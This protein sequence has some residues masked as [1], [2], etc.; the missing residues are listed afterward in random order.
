MPIFFLFVA[1]IL[2]SG[3]SE[4]ETFEAVADREVKEGLRALRLPGTDDPP[5][6]RLPGAK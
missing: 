3:K 4:P 6:P 2:L 1:V 5:P